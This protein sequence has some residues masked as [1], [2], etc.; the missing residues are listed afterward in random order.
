MNVPTV[1]LQISKISRAAWL[2]YRLLLAV[3]A[4][5]GAVLVLLRNATWGP[6][7]HWDSVNYISVARSLLAGEGLMQ[8]TGHLYT[9]WPPLYPLLLAA[10]SL[11]GFDPHAVAGPL[12]A[13]LFGL[14]ILVA[15]HWLRHRIASRLLFL[16]A[17]LAVTFALPLTSVASWALSEPVFI[18]FVTLGL[19]SMD[20]FLRG[21]QT[22]ALI[23]A[24][25]FTALACLTRYIGFVVVVALLPLVL[26]QPDAR[27]SAKVKRGAVYA[28]ISVI[29]ISLWLLRNLLRVGV[30]FGRF[31]SPTDDDPLRRFLKAVLLELSEW[32]LPGLS[33]SGL[34]LYAAA[35]AAAALAALAIAVGFALIRIYQKPTLRRQWSSFCLCGGFVLVYLTWVG[36]SSTIKKIHDFSEVRYWAVIYISLLFALVF[37][38]D[39]FLIWQRKRPQKSGAVRLPVIVTFVRRRGDLLAAVL[40]ILLFIWL[41]SAV[42]L[43]IQAV[44]KV[45]EGDDRGYAA[46]SWVNSDVIHFIREAQLKGTIFG[47]KLANLYI[48][49]DP[50]NDYR[51]IP[52]SRD[53]VCDWS[54]GMEQL[55]R[56]KQII[57]QTAGDRYLVW[58]YDHIN[59]K[60]PQY[61]YGPAELE[62]M[63]E[64]EPMAQLDDGIIFRIKRGL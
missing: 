6:G 4:V 7:L 33:S 50:A 35:L 47:N 32:V 63:P 23:W 17:C 39:R 26:L 37:L 49:T 62:A 34:R 11:P 12:N 59:W 51:S 30:P 56:L 3:L 58:F 29:P 46:P 19:F 25:L 1:T 36:I 57:D 38:L 13:F 27:L 16:W 8:F 22:A 31:S 14:T 42:R 55:E 20:R 18:L 48:H 54:C 15:G 5:A 61:G 64:L 60:N 41:G 44:A 2:R 45:S 53:P 40:G 43:N 24:A 10:I 21:D 9:H 28:L 52:L